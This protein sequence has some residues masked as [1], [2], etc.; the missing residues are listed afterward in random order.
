M[1]LQ[2]KPTNALMSLYHKHK[3]SNLAVEQFIACHQTTE[4][5][6]RDERVDAI[7][8]FYSENSSTRLR[9]HDLIVNLYLFSILCPQPLGG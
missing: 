9:A 3:Y 8:H 1:N 5:E 6:R 4:Q 2:N 7:P